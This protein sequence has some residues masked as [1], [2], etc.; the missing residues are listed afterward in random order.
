MNL[1]HESDFSNDDWQPHEPS[2]A[3][4]QPH[5]LRRFRLRVSCFIG[6]SLA[7]PGAV[8][9]APIVPDSYETSRSG[10]STSV[11]A[12]YPGAA[13]TI[14][15]QDGATADSRPSAM[16]DAR[17]TPPP[18]GGRPS[19]LPPPAPPRIAGQQGQR[20]PYTEG[21]QSAPAQE[22]MIAQI[23]LPVPPPTAQPLTF[24]ESTPETSYAAS[25]PA[26]QFEYTQPSRY[27]ERENPG[28]RE[29]PRETHARPV[30]RQ[31]DRYRGELIPIHAVHTTNDVN[32]ETPARSSTNPYSTA[33]T[34]AAAS[35]SRSTPASGIAVQD[36]VPV[37]E[38]PVSPTIV[39]DKGQ[40]A[41]PKPPGSDVPPPPDFGAMIQQKRYSEVEEAAVENSDSKLASALGWA[42][43][44]DGQNSLAYHWFERAIQ[45]DESNHEAS[46]GMA[47]T[48]FR[49]GR[50]SQAEEIARWRAPQYPKMKQV[51][52]DVAVRRAVSSFQAKQYRE[53]RETL[54]AIKRQ[55]PLTRE[56]Q[57]MLAWSDFHLGNTI[58]ARAEFLRLYRQKADRYAADGVYTT[59]ATSR[60]WTGLEKVVREYRGPLEALYQKYVSQKYYDYGLYREAYTQD[61]CA[62]PELQNISSSAAGVQVIARTRSGTEGT[63]Q[64]SEYGARANGTF[65]VKDVHRFDVS[66]GVTNLDSGQLNSGDPIGQVPPAGSTRGYKHALQTQYDGLVDARVRWEREGLL[67]PM[68]EVGITPINGAV[69]PTFVGRAGLRR[70]YDSGNWTA[71]IYRDPVKDSLLSYTG[72]RDP[73]TGKR[74]GRVTETGGRLSFYSQYPGDWGLFGAA[75]VGVLKGR[76]VP[77]N[78]H[79]ALS[80][81]LSK[82]LRLDGFDYFAVGPSLSMAFYDKNLSQFTYG[83]G[84]YFSPS[85]SLQGMIGARFLTHQGGTS[86]LRAGAGLGIQTNKQEGTPF[87]PNKPDG[88]WHGTT[89]STGTAVVLDLEGLYMLSPNWVVSGQLGVNVAPDYNDFSVRVGLQYFFDRR[90]GLFAQ[91]FM[92]F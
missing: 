40:Q 17:T 64:L 78:S 53:S 11:S 63:S 51:L 75:S 79:A 34:Y 48:L 45:W 52:A 85:H 10:S 19:F 61:P 22:T 88:R 41:I 38:E 81:A 30:P 27:A 36:T 91:D 29:S 47:L 12:S 25:T 1:I 5:A 43:Y 87:F 44:R 54:L 90:G 28:D 92:T 60:N 6:I 86:L 14:Y 59:Y 24:P 2:L 73:Y 83:Q 26:R 7:A 18:S 33:N 46:Y 66:V 20:N 50:Y 69:D 89:S 9:Q 70:V 42:R 74:W 31:P 84:G 80:V 77:D 35:S 65:Y 58:S 8:A 23:E 67:T 57:I 21:A 49:M 37:P 15:A 76:N 13:T 72:L 39:Y 3:A 62:R 82:D 32:D 4:I 71:E 55:R 56:E 68:L 16:A